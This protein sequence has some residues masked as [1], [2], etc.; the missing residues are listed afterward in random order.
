V[1]GGDDHRVLRTPYVIDDAEW[2]IPVV[3]AGGE[4]NHFLGRL[5]LYFAEIDGVWVLYEF[6]GI[7]LSVENVVP[8]PEIQS[9]ID[10]YI[11]M[12]GL[13]TETELVPA[14]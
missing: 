9:I 8:D 5:D 6:H 7:L 10:Y 14:A 12:L 2:P 13:E 3:Q 4:D 11:E 1:I